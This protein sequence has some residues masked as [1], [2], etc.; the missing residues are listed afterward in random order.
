[1]GFFD[2]LTEALKRPIYSDKEANLDKTKNTSQVSTE[3][4]MEV[5]YVTYDPFTQYTQSSL[6]GDM[7]RVNSNSELIKQWRTMSLMPEVDE[8]LQEICNEAIVYDEVDDVISLDLDGLDVP[9]KIKDKIQE[10]FKHILYLLDF[11][12]RGDEIFRQWYVDGVLRLEAIFDN[13]K[14]KEGIKKLVL[15]TPFNMFKYREEK[16]GIIKYFYCKDP[17]YNLIK[18]FQ[19]ADKIYLEDQITEI[20]SGLWDIDKKTPLSFLHKAYKAVNQ[21]STIEDSLIIFRITRSPEK[22]VFYID[23]GN[24]PKAKAEEY[25]RSLIT[26]YRQQK[27]YD[28]DSGK[29]QNK[30]RQISILEDFWFPVSQSGAGSRGTRV[31]SLQGQN[32]GFSDFSDINYFENKVY[33]ALGVPTKRKDVES[34]LQLSNTVD[35]EKDEL[36]FF[37]LILKL[38]RK[39]NN[40]LVDLL[41]K[42]LIAKSVFRI[43]DWV[44]IQEQLKFKYANSNEFS[45][46]KNLQIVGMKME[47]ATAALQLAEA[48]LISRDFIRRNIM[49]FSDEDI[50]ALDKQIEDEKDLPPI[51]GEVPFEEPEEEPEEEVTPEEE[52]EEEVTPEEEPEEGSKPKGKKGNPFS[53]RK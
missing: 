48:K 9:E 18:D 8:A 27:T 24:L 37:K 21:L 36:K 1:M 39:F 46:I 20:N 33:R 49:G 34:R 44:T 16:T 12:E 26:R 38:R 43:D 17:N 6:L 42:D 50:E 47:Y 45:T 7:A 11:N 2:L 32:P 40:L 41:K 14:M 13:N 53:K 3:K 52:P 19:K 22:R 51:S 28:V 23:T 30:S 10:S 5:T 31:E 15:L 4:E 35:V 25:V 29:V